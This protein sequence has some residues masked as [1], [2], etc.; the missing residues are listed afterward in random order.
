M[1]SS[2]AVRA[3]LLTFK[4]PQEAFYSVADLKWVNKSDPF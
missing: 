3:A 1:I 2:C 4:G